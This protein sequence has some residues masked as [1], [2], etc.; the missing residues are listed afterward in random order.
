M[1]LGLK[2][3]VVVGGAI[4][5][6]NQCAFA[7]N[8]T[9]D[10]TL[11]TAKT[12]APNGKNYT[13]QQT[14]GQ[15]VGKNLFHSFG[16]F[17]LNTG[18]TATF[19]SGANI[20]NIISRVTGGS[21]STI[22]GIISAGNVN[23]FLINPSGIFFGSNA[24]LNIGGSTR[25]SFVATT[26]D[27]LVW[28]N[29]GQFSATHPG[30]ASS[31]LTLVGDP[32]G[33]LS[34]LR[35]P[36]PI[37]TSG[38]NL[39]VSPGQ[40][41]VLLGGN[42]TFDKNTQLAAPGGQI[43]LASV[44]GAGTVGLGING[45]ILKLNIPDSIAR[46]D[47]SVNNG[48]TVDVTT[49]SNGGSIDVYGHNVDIL[50]GSQLKAGIAPGKGTESSQAGDIS[51]SVTGTF[52]MN[53]ANISDTVP[54]YDREKKTMFGKGSPGN[55]NIQAGG[56]ISIINLAS[57]PALDAGNQTNNRPPRIL[58]SQQGHGGN[59]SLQANGNISV[60][61]QNNNSN[62]QAISTYSNSPTSGGDISLKAKG[63]ISINDAY[64]VATNAGGNAGKILLQ[65]DRSVS[66]AN[67]SSLVSTAFFKQNSGDIR[68]E[69]SF[70]SVS[71]QNSLVST[72]VGQPSDLHFYSTL[73]NGG[74]I[75]ISGRSVSVTDGTEISSRAFNGF[76]SGNININ[77]S[78]I[79]ELSGYKL[80]SPTNRS[81]TTAYSALLTTSEKFAEGSGGNINVTTNVLR[82]SDGA[83]LRAQSDSAFSGGNI[84]VQANVIELLNG[85]QLLTSALN[86][87][88]AGTI[89]LNA[90]NRVTIDGSNP[91]ARAIYEQVAQQ[92][93]DNAGFI[94][95]L[96]SSSGKFQ[97][98][99]FAN[100][101]DTS[102]AEGG[103]IRITTG[104]LQVQNQGSITASSPQGQAGNLTITA[105]D[106]RLNQGFLTAETAKTNP[107]Q[108]GANITLRGLDFLLLQNGSQISAKASNDATG[109]NIRIDARNGVVVA[110]LSQGND[111]IASADR[112]TGG[113]VTITSEQIFGLTKGVS[114]GST[115][116]VDVSSQFS[117]PGTVTF[118]TLDIDLSLGLITLPTVVVDASRLV[119]TSCSAASR[120]KFNELTVTGRGG[121][122]PNPYEPLTSDAIWTDNRLPNI[123]NQQ[124]VSQSQHFSNQRAPLE[125][126]DHIVILPATG[127]VFNN[128]G[129]VTLIADPSASVPPN[130]S[131]C[132]KH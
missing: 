17:N 94:R 107:N 104:Q 114:G 28:G 31:L 63:S 123:T 93:S 75:T 129:E 91:N 26:L 82:V 30:G 36:Q 34:S 96:A 68:I 55:I 100:T 62:D 85:G 42:L 24:K 103:D 122:P 79:V 128:K 53:Q 15:T 76:K 57:N 49:A 86:N 116:V 118:N 112:G 72:A 40:S 58:G 19:E 124:K 47:V 18:E 70:G 101:S 33:F 43:E 78:D 5:F 10:G 46:G 88:N 131:I 7:Q 23:L 117:N 39:A 84:K 44:T 21:R 115:N 45:N 37:M 98:G 2:G 65:G 81:Q 77:A 106:I 51:I 113:N 14:D 4:A 83:S 121:L 111:I 11:G 25:G 12:L 69:S 22:D 48:T 29:G 64:F 89:K 35:P 92:D 20:Q 59:I 109:G 13:I 52:T 99:I 66:L 102:T 3:V 120:T 54:G 74:D 67:N 71:F 41:L 110:P 125:T 61:G 90:T 87:G 16:R 95:Q 119:D 27:G 132:P 38:S 1:R 127:W 130:T 56:D 60:F 50:G 8:I 97:S 9:I 32:S 80:Y 126:K 6:T 73:G 105:K 108:Q